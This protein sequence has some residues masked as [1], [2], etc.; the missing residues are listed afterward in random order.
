MWIPANSRHTDKIPP[1]S[2]PGVVPPPLQEIVAHIPASSRELGTSA[3]G[4][5]ATTAPAAE[6][7]ILGM[8]ISGAGQ[9]WQSAE[10]S[11]RTR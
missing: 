2:S 10:G 1:I 7:T 11:A 3:A 8:S 9:G 4:I 5:S 6:E